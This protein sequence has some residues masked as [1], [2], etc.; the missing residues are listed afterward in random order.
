[1]DKIQIKKPYDL[2]ERTLQ[3]TKDVI[4]LVNKAP[5]N[6]SN[7][8]IAKQLI[9]SS[10]SLGANY[11]EANES[12]GKKDFVMHARIARKEAK[13]SRYWLQLMECNDYLQ[14]LKDQLIQ[15]STELLKIL[16]KIIEKST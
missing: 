15:E 6:L 5:K 4:S 16:S 1:M 7:I 9:R 2:E 10:G 11:I 14:P 3:Y 8:E 12:L 13:E